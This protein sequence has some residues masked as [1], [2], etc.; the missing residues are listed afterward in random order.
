MCVYI[1]K[2]KYLLH[3]YTYIYVHTYI[4]AYI[5]AIIVKITPM[6]AVG[7]HTCITQIHLYPGHMK[8]G[9]LE[10]SFYDIHTSA[11]T[12]LLSMLMVISDFEWA[13]AC[14]E[15]MLCILYRCALSFS[16]SLSV[17][18]RSEKVL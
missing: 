17:S 11:N 8:M 6:H 15:G 5:H 2:Y 7:T 9:H 13:S 18:V 10:Y 4:P 3:V 14:R 12:M 1:Y 16:L